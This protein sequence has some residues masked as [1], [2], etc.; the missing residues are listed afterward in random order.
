MAEHSS[1]RF[2]DRKPLPF[3]KS[4]ND[5]EIRE[6]LRPSAFVPRDGPIGKAEIEP[7]KDPH[8][9]YSLRPGSAFRRYTIVPL[10]VFHDELLRHDSY[11]LQ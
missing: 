8:K 10:S 5:T 9:P 4:Q 1:C 6:F 2:I 7:Q 11:Y 3:P